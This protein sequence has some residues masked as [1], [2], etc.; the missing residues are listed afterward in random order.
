MKNKTLML[1]GILAPIVYV[2]TVI[3]GGIIRPG[4]SH[5]AQAVSDLIAAE[6]PNKALLDPLFAFYNILVAAFALGLFQLVRSENSNRGKVVGTVGAIVLAAQCTFG[7][8]TLLFPEPAGGMSVAIT[9]TGTMHIVFASLSALTS[10]LAILLMGFWFMNSQNL[11]A[12]ELYSFI[13]V[14]FV[15]LTGGLAAYS[16][17]SQSPF[18]GIFE[19][20]TI[21]GFLQWIFVSAA[22][23][24]ALYDASMPVRRPR[25]KDR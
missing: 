13:S 6:A 2:F 20:L 10:M 12:Y 9:S 3:L 18:G 22:K 19:R 25:S 7:L 14:T 21:G 17:A 16:V 1:A 24:Y 5:I 15:F 11:R 23:L 8:I 4:Y